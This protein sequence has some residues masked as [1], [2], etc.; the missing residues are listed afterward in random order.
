MSK[1]VPE[2]TELHEQDEV[3]LSKLTREILAMLAP[4]AVEKQIELEFETDEKMPKIYGNPT[5]LGILIRNLVDNSIRYSMENGRVIVR[6]LKH[7]NEIILEVCDN[8]PGIPPELQ[9]RVLKDFL[10]Y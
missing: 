2:A 3:N 6:L 10:E 4:S 1:L 5:A 7:N 8:G 9:K